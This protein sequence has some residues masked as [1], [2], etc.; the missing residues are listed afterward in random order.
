MAG[1]RHN[2]KR[3]KDPGAGKATSGDLDLG[4]SVK[5]PAALLR[6][7]FEADAAKFQ[8]KSP[9]LAA[10]FGYWIGYPSFLEWIGFGRDWGAHQ[11]TVLAYYALN[12]VHG[13]ATRV[14][15]KEATRRGMDPHALYECSRVVQ[16]IYLAA[17]ELC[18]R[19]TGAIHDGW[20]ECMGAA[21]YS[22]PAGQREA[23]RAGEAVF[24]RLAMVMDIAQAA[25]ALTSDDRAILQALAD[26]GTTLPQADIA[27]AAERD[28]KTAREHLK[29]LEAAGLVSRPCGERSGYTITPAGLGLLSSTRD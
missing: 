4:A 22:L 5:E 3:H 1:S 23:L 28:I 29:R 2:I 26:A 17:P 14:L 20:P 19:R 16:E 15:M 25:P 10:V 9:D 12:H 18:V 11:D 24:I 6:R 27:A 7:A 21:R 8:G 13:E